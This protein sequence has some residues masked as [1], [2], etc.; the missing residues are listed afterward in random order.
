MLAM[1]VLWFLRHSHGHSL[2]HTLP[3]QQTD[4]SRSTLALTQSTK[5]IATQCAAYGR[6]PDLLLACECSQMCSQAEREGG[7]G[8]RARQPKKQ[9]SCVSLVS[10]FEL[11]CRC[12]ARKLRARELV[13]S[14][15]ELVAGVAQGACCSPWHSPRPVEGGRWDEQSFLLDA[16]E[17]T[18]KSVRPT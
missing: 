15:A 5:S 6:M 12:Y 11:G 1:G 9:G 13:K 7:G 18:Y 14:T 16:H 4:P 3:F 17:H 8:T 10:F 2:A